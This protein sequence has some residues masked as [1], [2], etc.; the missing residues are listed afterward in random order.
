MTECYTYVELIKRLT[1][2]GGPRHKGQ[3]KT[4]DAEVKEATDLFIYLFICEV[5]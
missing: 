2:L 5:K 3:N 1:V 4:N